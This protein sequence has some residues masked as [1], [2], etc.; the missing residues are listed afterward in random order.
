M[1]KYQMPSESVDV[2]CEVTGWNGRKEVEEGKRVLVYARAYICE[3]YL[4]QLATPLNGDDHWMHPSNRSAMLQHGT[5]LMFSSVPMVQIP[6]FGAIML[7]MLSTS[8]SSPLLSIDLSVE[9][10]ACGLT[11]VF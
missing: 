6:A 7:L 5:A 1:S 9:L 2:Q 10:L 8:I 11:F 4:F 3:T